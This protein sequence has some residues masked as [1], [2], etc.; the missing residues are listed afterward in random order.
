MTDS[1]QIDDE[2]ERDIERLNLTAPRVTPDQIEALMA[3]VT[4]DVHVVP[5]TTTTLATSHRY[6]RA[7]QEVLP[8]RVRAGSQSM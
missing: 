6:S 7:S 3:G 4:Y 2:M 1:Q 5:G 8:S